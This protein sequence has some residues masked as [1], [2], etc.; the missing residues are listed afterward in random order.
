MYRDFSDASKQRLLGLVKEVEDEKWSDFTDWIGDRWLDFQGWI[1]HLN[2]KNYIDDV[3]TYHKKVIDKNNTT[4]EK[5]EKIFE[6]VAVV[7]S[8]YKI[9]LQDDYDLFSQIDSYVLQSATIVNPLNGL[10]EEDYIVTTLSSITF[11]QKLIKK[12]FRI[13]LTDEIVF[14][15]DN[16]GRYGGDQGRPKKASHEERELYY[17]IIKKNNPDPN[18]ELTDKQLSCYLKK[19]NSEGCG[20]VALI[21]TIFCY[22]LDDPEEFEE[23]F[24]YPMYC[25]NGQL[26]YEMLLVDL[27]SKTDNGGDI[28]GDYDEKTDGP[29]D[30]YDPWSDTTG[31]GSSQYDREEYLEHFMVE[32]GVEVEVTTDANVTS[33]NVESLISEGKM[34]IIAYRNGNLHNMNGSIA[35]PINGG[36]AMV[37]TGVTDEGYMIVSSWGG[38]YYID[39][40]EIVELEY[41]GVKHTTSMTFSTVEYE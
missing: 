21:N 15:P 18:F 16:K 10:F 35:Q 23:T 27:Y 12:K 38:Q 11:F 41:D 5:I 20:Y 8:S 39:P 31:H 34:I 19:I 14:N 30:S 29:K 26:N 3:N 4:S 9:E 13:T 36:H 32:H 33:D 28:Y 1:G 6:D 25:E 7:D 37:V 22:Y 40:D 24:G 2:I 17:Q